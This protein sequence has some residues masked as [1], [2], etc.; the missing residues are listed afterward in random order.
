MH[1]EQYCQTKTTHFCAGA[2]SLGIDA[3]AARAAA[4]NCSPPTDELLSDEL[5][6]RPTAGADVGGGPAA[7]V[8]EKGG[9]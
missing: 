6:R 1:P 7:R 2:L 8:K 4:A 5:A 3:I 9:Q